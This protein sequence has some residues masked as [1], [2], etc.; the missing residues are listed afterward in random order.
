MKTTTTTCD[1]CG[2][3]ILERG[4]AITVSGELRPQLERADF[5]LDCAHALLSFTRER[6]RAEALAAPAPRA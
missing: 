1:R 2:S 5:C 3:L 4:S 6:E